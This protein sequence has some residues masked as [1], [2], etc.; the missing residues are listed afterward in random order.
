MGECLAVRGRLPFAELPV[1]CAIKD[2]GNLFGVPRLA[3]L[4]PVIDVFRSCLV[5]EE[6]DK[7]RYNR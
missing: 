4:V 7:A 5:K 6:G 2:I 1:P 3:V